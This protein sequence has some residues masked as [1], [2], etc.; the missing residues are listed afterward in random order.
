[1]KLALTQMGSG[2]KFFA[3]THGA[4]I[5]GYCVKK[6]G[7]IKPFG[8]NLSYSHRYMEMN[9]CNLWQFTNNKPSNRT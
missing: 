8:D 4:M 7:M 9:E 6:L 3:H 2:N 1:M 5:Q